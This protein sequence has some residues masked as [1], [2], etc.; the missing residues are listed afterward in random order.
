MNFDLIHPLLIL[1]K[2]KYLYSVIVFITIII[3]ISITFSILKYYRFSH[4]KELK[5]TA[6]ISY[7]LK[8]LFSLLFKKMYLY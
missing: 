8:L 1:Q 7:I 5:L 2:K 3:N 4:I 6:L